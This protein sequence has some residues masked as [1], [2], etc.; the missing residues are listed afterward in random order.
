MFCPHNS[1]Q[2]SICKLFIL[3]EVPPLGDVGQEFAALKKLK[4][5]FLKK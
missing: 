1:H 3:Q 4:E 5:F 2:F